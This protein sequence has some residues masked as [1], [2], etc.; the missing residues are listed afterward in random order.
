MDLA[1]QR[2]RMVEEQ[3]RRRGIADTRVLAAMGEI[4]R[5]AYIPESERHHAYVDG[6]LPLSHNRNYWTLKLPTLHYCVYI[7]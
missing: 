1:K 4:P 7:V 5:E 3:L 2:A 6:A